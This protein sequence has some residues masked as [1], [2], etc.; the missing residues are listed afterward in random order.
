MQ[1]FQRSQAE[2]KMRTEHAEAVNEFNQRLNID[3]EF[4]KDAKGLMKFHPRAESD[5]QK[6]AAF[7][8]ATEA[9]RMNRESLDQ[10]VAD[11]IIDEDQA[12]LFAKNSMLD[13]DRVSGQ[14][15]TLSGALLAKKKEDSRFQQV[16]G[17]A[18]AA[19]KMEDPAAGYDSIL[20][21]PNLD[22]GTRASA[23]NAFSSLRQQKMSL[24][25]R[26]GGGRA[27]PK[28]LGAFPPIAQDLIR[29]VG[30]TPKGVNEA[31]AKFDKAYSDMGTQP[32]AEL[33][34]K[35]I[36]ALEDQSG[37]AV[38]ATGQSQEELIR[39]QQIT[40][41]KSTVLAKY[42]YDL[43][44]PEGRQW[45]EDSTEF[46][47]E[48]SAEGFKSAGD[49]LAGMKV[50]DAKKDKERDIKEDV[51]ASSGL[52]IE[53]LSRM[54]VNTNVDGKPVFNVSS[55]APNVAE[56][57]SA[58]SQRDE[59]LSYFFTKSPNIPGATST[60]VAA[61][62]D[63]AVMVPDIQGIKVKGKPSMLGFEYEHNSIDPTLYLMHKNAEGELVR[64]DKVSK[65]QAMKSADALMSHMKNN[66]GA[67]PLSETKNAID[68]I[69]SIIFRDPK[70]RRR[71]PSADRYAPVLIPSDTP[72]GKLY[73]RILD[74]SKAIEKSGDQELRKAARYY[75]LTLNAK[76][77]LD[78][79]HLSV[80][81]GMPL[82]EAA[83]A[84]QGPIR[85]DPSVL[86]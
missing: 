63:G 15:A 33:R 30:P 17:L 52:V 60:L 66:M 22:E 54:G 18:T 3:K 6:F 13:P 5:P 75:M 67:D 14:L 7:T 1:M 70:S 31:L 74:E 65:A 36:K 37:L 82:Q 26:Q 19:L 85:F 79:L 39:D 51:V 81:K 59:W 16:Q 40:S 8:A 38:K 23:L 42:G 80:S 10:M 64:G 44:T 4:A 69:Q 34:A 2:T 58:P 72:S 9:H 83:A 43:D 84:G 20:Y 29:S 45:A 12:K 27:E 32:P 73:A 86:K 61:L 56:M 57:L 25:A 46:R 76:T 21:N 68:G 50:F 55:V 71:N 41:L 49:A 62:D 78:H 28:G 48:A 24:A 53:R 77:A 11:Q 47:D 35:F